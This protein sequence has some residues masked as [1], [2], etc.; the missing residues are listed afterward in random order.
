MTYPP[1]PPG[2]G[3]YGPPPPDPYG[4]QQPG[5]YGP[6]H[7]D[8]FG[9]QPGQYGPPPP[10]DQYGP[11]TPYQGLGYPGAPPPP[12]PKKKNTM[13][14]VIVLVAVLVIGGAATTIFLMTRD[15]GGTGSSA[16]PNTETAGPEE[17][18]G[19]DPPSR[20]EDAPT[21]SPAAV[22]QAY[23]DAYESKQFSTVVESAC[24]AYKD[25]FG[26]DTSKLEKQLEPYDIKAENAGDPEVTGNTATALIDL[27]LTKDGETKTP[28]IKIKIVKEG[29]Q[30]R[31]CGEG[32]A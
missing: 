18:D 12:P 6:Q 8:P 7:P 5:M 29:G 10:A 24:Q 27:E 14:V 3:P 2:G 23:I 22:Q 32:E 1:Q 30:W 13:M 26:T 25:K 17:D 20:T 11:P 21:N 31:F 16:S 28:H 4:Q 15:S 19:N 9:G